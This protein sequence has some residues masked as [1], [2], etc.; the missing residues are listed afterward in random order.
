MAH[1]QTPKQQQWFFEFSHNYSLLPSTGSQHSQSKSGLCLTSRNF[2]QQKYANVPPSR[3]VTPC[4][5]LASSPK[6]FQNYHSPQTATV[7][8]RAHAIAPAPGRE[9]SCFLGP[10]GLGY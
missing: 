8:Q 6:I 5:G 10:R 9:K 1:L 7:V 3:P 2:S 4:P